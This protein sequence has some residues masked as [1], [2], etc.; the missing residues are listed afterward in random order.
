MDRS[1]ARAART[2]NNAVVAD[3]GP[4]H[5]VSRSPKDEQVRS[6]GGEFD[7]RAEPVDKGQDA[8][9]AGSEMGRPGFQARDIVAQA[10]VLPDAAGFLRR[11]AELPPLDIDDE[12]GLI[13]GHD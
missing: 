3:L 8:A 7:L 6:E 1:P 13:G 2:H 5:E 12:P 4:A 10:P 11:A 9:K